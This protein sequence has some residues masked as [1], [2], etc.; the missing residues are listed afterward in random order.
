MAIRPEYAKRIAIHQFKV[1]RHSGKPLFPYSP[2]NHEAKEKWDTL[3]TAASSEESQRDF[4]QEFVTILESVI[5]TVS[6]KTD[7]T[8]ILGGLLPH[9]L[10][11]CEAES[12]AFLVVGDETNLHNGKANHLIV[13]N[14]QEMP[15]EIIK[16]LIKG[17]LTQQLLSGQTVWLQPQPFQLNAEQALLGRHKLKY[18]LGLP[19]QVGDEVLGAVVIAS[20]SFNPHLAKSELEHRLTTLAQIVALFLD[21]LRLKTRQIQLQGELAQRQVSA[22]ANKKDDLEELL[23]AVMSAEEE[24]VHQNRDL[25]LLN[26][27]SHEIAG[28]LQLNAILEAAVGQTNN[29]LQAEASWCY[30]YENGSLI[31][32]EQRGLSE[33]YASG[34][35]FL[36]PGNGVEGMAF[37]RKQP[38]VRDSM[39]FH[40]GQARTL[41]KEEGLRMVA[42]V[43]LV[44]Q[45]KI[46]GVLAAAKHHQQA[47]SAR[48]E[49]ML[50]SIGRQVA[51]AIA[52]SH[53]F[54]EVQ[55]KAQTWE[56]NYSSLQQ[57]NAQL[58]RRA[59]LLERQVQDLR[60]I[61]KQIWVML[62]ASNEARRTLGKTTNI[63]DDELVTALKRVLAAISDKHEQLLSEA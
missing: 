59:E 23:A 31:L 37:S 9:A 44:A 3:Q 53:Q 13:V 20:R 1:R 4:D 52:N 58:A 7:K 40:T 39:L 29:L 10:A 30:M 27:F 17:P 19:L 38:I 51:Q 14:R 36:E 18:L 16:H 28:T 26:A 6:Q 55:T 2:G 45:G 5:G 21:N 12:G 15:D 22:A 60:Q 34:M 46:F 11:V 57:T 32:R 24:V 25:G 43:P 48:D 33:R 63:Y 41:L 50:A 35:K 56:A 8:K 47:W 61:E 62:A 49:R 42:A 54:A